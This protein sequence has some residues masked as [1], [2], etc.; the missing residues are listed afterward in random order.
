MNIEF[1]IE[2]KN[3][4]FKWISNLPINNEI[5]LFLCVSNAEHP[6][7]ESVIT[8]AP[9]MATLSYSLCIYYGLFL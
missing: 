7:F 9:H 3:R 2:K 4:K 1:L 6:T 5:Y 8:A